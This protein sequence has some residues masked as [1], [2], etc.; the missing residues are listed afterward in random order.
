MDIEY[1]SFS[2]VHYSFMLCY[3]MLLLVLFR[4]PGDLR[5]SS[6]IT[7]GL[8]FIFDV[9]MNDLPVQSIAQ[10]NVMRIM[11]IDA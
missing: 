6:I 5:V 3:V 8:L 9:D 7:P 4:D 10:E 11:S 1:F 2:C